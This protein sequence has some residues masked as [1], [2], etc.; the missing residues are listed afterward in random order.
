M[1]EK[2]FHIKISLN[3]CFQSSKRIA[4]REMTV[5]KIIMKIVEGLEAEHPGIAG[6]EQELRYTSRQTT[7]CF[8]VIRSI[9]FRSTVKISWIDL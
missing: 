3:R 2:S 8:E 6:L 4:L 7:S 5:L 1:E 9:V